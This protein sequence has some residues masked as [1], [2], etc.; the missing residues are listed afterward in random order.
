MPSRAAW[1]GNAAMRARCSSTFVG[2][3]SVRLGVDVVL[4]VWRQPYPVLR[5]SLVPSEYA[6]DIFPYT[7]HSQHRRF[8]DPREM[9]LYLA[10]REPHRVRYTT[11]DGLFHDE[12]IEVKYE[13]TTIEC[14]MQFQGDLRG[15]DLVD[16]YDVDVAW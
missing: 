9:E 1:Y 11:V 7:L 6:A 4:R 15:K 13:F 10:F 14:S 16:W 12:Y 8:G 2:L 5:R 3:P